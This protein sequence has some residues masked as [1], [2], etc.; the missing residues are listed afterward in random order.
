MAKSFSPIQKIRDKQIQEYVWTIQEQLEKMQSYEEDKKR[1]LFDK[2]SRRLFLEGEALPDGL[3]YTFSKAI[4][5][6]E[7]SKHTKEF[8]IPSEYYNAPDIDKPTSILPAAREKQ[9]EENGRKL[10]TYLQISEMSIENL[11]D[12]YQ[13]IISTSY[14]EGTMPEEYKTECIYNALLAKR[15]SLIKSDSKRS[16]DKIL[17]EKLSLILSKANIRTDFL[18]TKKVD[19]QI[20]L[21]DSLYFVEFFREN[22]SSLPLGYENHEDTL[23]RSKD[24]LELFSRALTEIEAREQ[25]NGNFY[26]YLKEQKAKYETLSN[27]RIKEGLERQKSEELKVEAEAKSAKRR[28][29]VAEYERQRQEREESAARAERANERETGAR[30]AADYVP[31]GNTPEYAA[32]HNEGRSDSGAPFPGMNDYQGPNSAGGEYEERSLDD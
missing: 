30:Y 26:I 1:A 4:Y 21:R 28:A 11:L 13:T 23:A 20:A 18:P 6:K 12:A 2:V 29:S 22:T 5:G 3:A 16:Q 7:A 19:R 32:L 10:D 8:E 9:I 15:N 17:Q 27:Q 24:R 25:T 14:S 31:D